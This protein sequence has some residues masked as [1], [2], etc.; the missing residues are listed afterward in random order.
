MTATQ[1]IVDILGV[2]I[3]RAET[4]QKIYD[5]TLDGSKWSDA[6]FNQIIITANHVNKEIEKAVA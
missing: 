6:S 2:S 4:I 3:E 1:A 5:T